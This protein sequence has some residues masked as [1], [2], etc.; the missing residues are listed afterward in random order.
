MGRPEAARIN[1]RKGGRP[2]WTHIGCV[3]GDCPYTEARGEGGPEAWRDW[4]CP[5]HPL[6]RTVKIYPRHV[7]KRETNGKSNRY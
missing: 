5:D 4:R 2:P 1:G 3:V 7:G 6:A